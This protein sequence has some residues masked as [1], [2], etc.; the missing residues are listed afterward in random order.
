MTLELQ[1]PT[2]KEDYG[3][4]PKFVDTR[5]K[6]RKIVDGKPVDLEAVLVEGLI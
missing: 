2:V 1:R 4:E 5:Q 6:L 3:L